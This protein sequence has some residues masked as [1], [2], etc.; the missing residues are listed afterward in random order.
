MGVACLV[1]G[2]SF[3]AVGNT[4]FRIRRRALGILTFTLEVA[5]GE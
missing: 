5:K 2:A 4:D 1:V 3:P